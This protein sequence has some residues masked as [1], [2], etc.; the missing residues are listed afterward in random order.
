MRL[1]AGQI[2]GN[3]W[4]DIK[5]TASR[6]EAAFRLSNGDTRFGRLRPASTYEPGGFLIIVTL[7]GVTRF[8]RA[9]ALHPLTSLAGFW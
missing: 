4:D 9:R 1:S 3:R 5:K 8:G 6:K 7:L 2:S